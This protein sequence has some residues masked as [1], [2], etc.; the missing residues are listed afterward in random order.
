MPGAQSVLPAAELLERLTPR[1]DA[2]LREQALHVRP[3]GVLRDEQPLGDL[4]GAEMPVEQEQHLELACR[5]R[6]RDLLRDDRSRTSLPYLI[7]QAPRDRSR[8]GRLTLRD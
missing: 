7:E 2:E 1:R 5:H 4:V 3:D 8:E 6:L